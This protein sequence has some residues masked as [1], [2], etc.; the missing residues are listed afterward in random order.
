MKISR[1]SESF[2]IFER[3]NQMQQKSKDK[4]RGNN[5]DGCNTRAAPRTQKAIILEQQQH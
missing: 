4:G 1:K 5:T 3:Q 2:N